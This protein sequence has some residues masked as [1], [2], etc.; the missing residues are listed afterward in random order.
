MNITIEKYLNETNTVL[1]T[2]DS[3]TRLRNIVR[4][5]QKIEEIVNQWANGSDLADS[6]VAISEVIEDGKEKIQV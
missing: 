3:F 6:M 5:Y 2:Q 1:V 4:K